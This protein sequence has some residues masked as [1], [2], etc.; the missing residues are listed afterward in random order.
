MKYGVLTFFRN[1]RMNIGD[2]IMSLGVRNIYKKMGIEDKDIV[3]VD[4]YHLSSYDG[5]YVILPMASWID[6]NEGA[7]PLSKKIIPIFLGIHCVS[8]NGTAKELNS[9]RNFGPFGC[10]DEAT[11]EVLRKNGLEAYIFG[12]LSFQSVELRK[13]AAQQT[14]VFLTEIPE[15]LYEYM[16]E[17]IKKD[18]VVLNHVFD[19]PNLDY[20]KG[21]LKEIDLAKKYLSRYRDEARLVITTRLHCALPCISMGIPVIVVRASEKRGSRLPD[22]RFCGFDKLFSFYTKDEYDQINWNPAAINIEEIKRKQLNIAVRYIREA[23]DK[24]SD[25]CDISDYFENRKSAAY[26][27][28]VSVGYLTRQQKEQFLKGKYKEKPLLSLMINK[29]LWKTNLIIYGAGDKGKWMILKF[30]NEMEMFKSC[31]YVDR[32][33]AKQNKKLHGYRILDP[34][35]LDKYPLDET[36]IIIATNHSYDKISQDIAQYLCKRYGMKEGKNYFMLDKLIVSAQLAISDAGMVKSYLHD[37][38][39]Y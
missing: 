39:W 6:Y 22:H 2:T 8:E 1:S 24:Y 25:L 14:K 37:L 29:D 11:M 4:V 9:Y 26:F 38:T 31:I 17:S 20:K 35:V 27:S 13:K 5:E 30:K 21:A 16:P 28:G 34:I 7:F 23:Y 36:I 32:D 10:R 18:S 3:E 12:C 33:E 15:E 19:Y